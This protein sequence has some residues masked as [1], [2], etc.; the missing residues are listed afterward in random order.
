VLAIPVPFLCHEDS[1]RYAQQPFRLECAALS[2]AMRQFKAAGLV[3]YSRGQISIA[4]RDGLRARSCSCRDIIAA[5]SL[6]IEALDD[7]QVGA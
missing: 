3:R 2:V 6:R 4:D 5:E 1:S 7:A